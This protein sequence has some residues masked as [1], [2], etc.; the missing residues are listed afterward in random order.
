[1]ILFLFIIVLSKTMKT[2]CYPITNYIIKSDSSCDTYWR[3]LEEIGEEGSHAEIWSVCCNE[4]CNHVLKYM[5]YENN[6]F[7]AILNEMRIQNGCSIIGLCPKIEDAWIC[8]DG[9]VI[10]MD[11]YEMTVKQLLL[12]FKTDAVRNKILAHV[13]SMVDK[14]HI[15]G[16]FHGDLHLDNIMV[17]STNKTKHT[18]D[19]SKL[20]DE[21][22]YKYYFIDFGNGGTF[23]TMDDIHV[24][25]DYIEISAHLRDLIDEYP[26]DTGFVRLYE[27]MKI[28]MKKFDKSE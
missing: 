27:I 17:K 5:P 12:E 16:I 26:E 4:N 14:L 23:N 2:I 9:G 28:Y 3:L 6:T 18:E 19:E 13:V 8:K 25:D 22:E 24:E 20:Y 10:V 21:R 1:M 11:L 15:K 7:D